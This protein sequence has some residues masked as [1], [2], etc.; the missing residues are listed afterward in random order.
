MVDQVIWVDWTTD[1]EIRLLL[2]VVGE[3]MLLLML[4]VVVLGSVVV[5]EMHLI[6]ELLVEVMLEKDSVLARSLEARETRLAVVE[7]GHRSWM[8]V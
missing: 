3:L 4:W 8:Y 5:L 1:V 7:E 6:E 2:E